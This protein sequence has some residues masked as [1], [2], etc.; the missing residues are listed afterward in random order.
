VVTE[1]YS[2][3][4]PAGDVAS[5]DPAAGASV[6][7]ETAVDLMVSLGPEPVVTET[8]LLPGDVPL[9]MVWIRPGKFMMG[10]YPDEQDSYD[11]EDP[12]HEVALAQGFWMGQY[13]LTKGQWTAVMGTTPWSECWYV[14]NDPDSAAVGVSWD[15][16]QAF[17]TAL[18]KCTG[19]TFR[20]PSE[21]EWEYACRAGTATRFYWGDD[22]GY[23]AINDYAWWEGNHWAG[24]E[25]AKVVGLKLPNVWGLYDMSG[26]ACE[27]VQDSW[28]DNYRGAPADG[29]AWQSPPE[30][31]LCVTRGGGW[32]AI[33]SRCRSAERLGDS[34]AAVNYDH[35]GFRLAR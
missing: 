17:I 16:A 20:L 21:A 8:I 7:P 9:V 26:N 27:Y 34:Y 32:F 2:D 18:N 25:Y 6:A 31:W 12:Q 10:R 19:Q 28:Y 14:T 1:Q 22:P 23:R 29:S 24:E 13:E 35:V 30:R 3:T 5:Q 33:G 11:D 4:V 15:D